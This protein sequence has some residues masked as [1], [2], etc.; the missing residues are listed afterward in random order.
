[1]ISQ[2]HYAIGGAISAG[3]GIKEIAG[4]FIGNSALGY[5]NTFGGGAIFVWNNRSIESVKGNFIGNYTNTNGGAIYSDS[6]S[7]ITNIAG[8]FAG[9]F[10]SGKQLS[11]GG[12]ICNLGIIG[13]ISASFINN[14]AKTNSTSQL[15]L[16]GAIYTREDLNIAADNKN[17]EF[18]G[19]YT[20]LLY[21]SDAADE[22]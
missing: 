18:T 13:E 15:A 11:R 4:N 17:I 5:S 14:S 2:S 21:T 10:V 16:G 6:N 20:C 1:M 8:L 12:A 19:N 9:N 7:N 3:G 22:L